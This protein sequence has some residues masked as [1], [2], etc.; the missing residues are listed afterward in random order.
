MQSAYEKQRTLEQTERIKKQKE[1]MEKAKR[2][3]ADLHR[4]NLEKQRSLL[5]KIKR[6]RQNS[7][8]SLILEAQ[9]RREFNKIMVFL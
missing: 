2:K 5:E 1:I 9:K 4:T 8:D 7:Y 3:A 6:E